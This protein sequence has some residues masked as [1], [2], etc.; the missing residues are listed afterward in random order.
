[1]SSPQEIAARLGRLAEEMAA[2]GSEIEYYAGFDRAWQEKGEALLRSAD[3]CR[4][5]AEQIENRQ[6]RIEK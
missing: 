3:V 2:L 5:W 4:D 6:G 1:M